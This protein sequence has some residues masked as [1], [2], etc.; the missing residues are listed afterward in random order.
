MLTRRK[1]SF[2]LAAAAGSGATSAAGLGRSEERLG[3]R[4]DDEQ[5]SRATRRQP[6]RAA[7][8][9]G[10]GVTGGGGAPRD[11]AS[12]APA[13]ATPRGSRSARSAPRAAHVAIVEQ[14][15]VQRQRQVA[16]EAVV[17]GGGVDELEQRERRPPRTAAP[18]RGPKIANG[19]TSSSTR[20]ARL[21]KWCHQAGR[22]CAYKAS[23]VGS[24]AV[25]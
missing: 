20:V 23:R 12:A 13:S 3:Q 9:G 7:V 15:Q 16:E 4:H 14:E 18:R 24:G 17:R 8:G 21:S 10:G 5:P 1:P 11:R 6:A 22:W 2:E 25:S 19:T